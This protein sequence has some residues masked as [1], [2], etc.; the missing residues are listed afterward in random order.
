V[1]LYVW[2]PAGG[3]SPRV[4]PQLLGAETLPALAAENGGPAS[5]KK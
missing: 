5:A 1:P 2:Y 4:L 3:G